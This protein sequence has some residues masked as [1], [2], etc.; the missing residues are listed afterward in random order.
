[1]LDKR[2]SQFSGLLIYRSPYPFAYKVFFILKSFVTS[3]KGP[4]DLVSDTDPEGDLN[5]PISDFEENS[6]SYSG[7]R[8]FIKVS[9]NFYQKFTFENRHHA[10]MLDGE[11]RVK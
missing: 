4:D 2:G 10:W 11:K 6:V 1:M 5:D 7:D 3:H 8:G 9:L